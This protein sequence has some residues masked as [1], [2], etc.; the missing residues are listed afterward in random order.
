MRNSYGPNGE[1]YLWNKNTDEIHDLEYEKPGCD[2]V[3]LLA[4]EPYQWLHTFPE[5]R[6]NAN[7]VDGCKHCMPEK[8]RW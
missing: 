3:N 4:N 8:H 6:W 1:R 5:A 2:I 7:E